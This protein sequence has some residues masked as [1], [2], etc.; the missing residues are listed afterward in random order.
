MAEAILPEAWLMPSAFMRRQASMMD[1]RLSRSFMAGH[2]VRFAR[3]NGLII[4]PQ[5]SRTWP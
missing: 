2:I 3:E 1:W 5:Y 4:A